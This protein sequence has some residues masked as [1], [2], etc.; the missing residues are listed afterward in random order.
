ML[1][2]WRQSCPRSKLIV[3]VQSVSTKRT[4]ITKN[5]L[6]GLYISTIRIQQNKALCAFLFSGEQ[7]VLTQPDSN[8]DLHFVFL[9]HSVSVGAHY[10]MRCL[11]RLAWGVSSDL[12]VWR[13]ISNSRRNKNCLERIK[14]VFWPMDLTDWVLVYFMVG[15]IGRK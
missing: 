7:P 9:P 11:K 1:K 14:R 6:H 3:D 8:I 10:K 4:R 5:H 2:S 15:F 12:V 13:E